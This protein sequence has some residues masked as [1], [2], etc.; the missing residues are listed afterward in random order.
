MIK[1]LKNKNNFMQICKYNSV[2]SKSF[3]TILNL[4]VH[5]HNLSIPQVALQAQHH[6]W[7]YFFV[8]QPMYK[9]LLDTVVDL[10]LTHLSSA[11]VVEELENDLVLKFIKTTNSWIY[12]KGHIIKINIK[13]LNR[14]SFIS[15]N[16][17]CT[18]CRSP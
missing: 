9:G 4:P 6:C 1:Y 18:F 5:V 14:S 2:A 13:Y 17:F 10:H 15:N 16:I 11:L 7:R 3:N 12:F 8:A